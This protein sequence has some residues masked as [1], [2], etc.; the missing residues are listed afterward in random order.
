MEGVGG[1]TVAP[2]C[3][4]MCGASSSEPAHLLP[5]LS[6]SGDGKAALQPLSCLENGFHCGLFIVNESGLVGGWG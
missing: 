3:Q 4:L 1:R 5:V 2:W 6:L